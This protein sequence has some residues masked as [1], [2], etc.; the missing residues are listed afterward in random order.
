VKRG[1]QWPVLIALSLAFTV[2]VNVVML[3]AAGSD[4]NGTVV[5]PDYYRK[6]VEWD[7]TMARRAASASLGW[8]ATAE[9][10]GAEPAGGG[11]AGP[12]ASS[13]QRTS[14]TLHVRLRD[15]A[16]VAISDAEVS[17][18]LIHNR[19]ASTPVSVALSADA[20][21]GYVGTGVLAHGGQWEVRVVARR[22]AERFE[23]SL[24]VEA[25]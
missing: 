23:T 16:G 5:E 21:G 15:A 17:A 18:T 22:G 7:R 20:D 14:R 13:V 2:G 12:L 4:P 3:F 9:L 6:A 11:D 1:W 10:G 8:S 19:E 25:P 24:R